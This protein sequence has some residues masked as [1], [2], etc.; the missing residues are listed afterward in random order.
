[1]SYQGIVCRLKVRPHP[2]ADRLQ[3]GSASGYQVVTSIDTKEG[4]LGVVFPADGPGCLSEKFARDNNLLR[5][6][7]DPT[8]GKPLGYLEDNARVKPV[9][10]R[11][12]V[13]EGIFLPLDSVQ[14]V[15]VSS[16]REGDSFSH[17]DGVEVCR[18]YAPVRHLSVLLR[19]SGKQKPSIRGLTVPHFY[20]VGDTSQ[21]RSMIYGI[22]KGAVLYFTEKLHGTSARTGKHL[23]QRRKYLEGW[24]MR[25]AR[26]LHRPLHTVIE[27]V[28]KVSGTRR[29]VLNNRAERFHADEFREVFHRTLEP[30]EGETIYYE[31]VGFDSNGKSIMSSHSPGKGDAD[32][33]IRKQYGDTIFYSYGQEPGTYEAYVYRI[34][35]VSPNGK[36]TRL[37]EGDMRSRAAELGMKAVPLLETAVFDG[38][39]DALIAKCNALSGGPSTLDSSHPR[40]GVCIRVDSP[41]MRGTYKWKGFQ[42]CVLEGNRYSDPNY[43]DEEDGN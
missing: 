24:R 26:I 39:V 41:E 28:E 8:T 11:G 19:E 40:E 3:I 32:K 13:S 14:G 33:E 36:A 43:V 35:V 6:Q 27:E 34:D 20:E 17:L 37:S 31:V 1:M 18:K 42:F 9:K 15:D 30:R 12:V 16:L 22:P 2:N 21:V 5:S 25:L 38:D 29:V 10:L 4:T 23:V 7:K